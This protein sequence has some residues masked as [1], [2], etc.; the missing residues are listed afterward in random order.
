MGRSR[1]WLVCLV[2]LAVLAAPFVGATMDDGATSDTG[3]E[4]AGPD[5]PPDPASTGASGPAVLA[6]NGSVAATTTVGAVDVGTDET[7]TVHEANVVSTNG[8][9]AD[10][11]AV[12]VDRAGSFQLPIQTHDGDGLQLSSGHRALGGLS[13]GDDWVPVSRSTLTGTDNVT[14]AEVS[15]GES[16]TV[17]VDT[18]P[19]NVPAT[20][21]ADPAQPAE[22]GARPPSDEDDGLWPSI[23]AVIRV[24]AMVLLCF[25]VAARFVRE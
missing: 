22:P 16:G 21:A 2:V 10:G 3:Q 7:A 14:P 19:A 17:A 11:L 4:S 25:A 13:V 12:R 24:A 6:G 8:S 9:L 5:E 18:G 20:T 23:E 1:L 15:M